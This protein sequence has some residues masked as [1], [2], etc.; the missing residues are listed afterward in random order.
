MKKYFFFFLLFLLSPL[1][2][3]AK[4]QYILQ[5]TENI[6]KLSGSC[7]FDVKLVLTEI[8]GEK[9]SI[10]SS[11]T[12]CKDGTFTFS[13]D[14]SIWNIADGQYVLWVNGEPAEKRI[15]MK[16]IVPITPLVT[17]KKK[18][19]PRNTFEQA[20]FNFGKNLTEMS[21]SLGIMEENLPE[22][23]YKK[24]TVKRTLIGFLRTTLDTLASFFGDFTSETDKVRPSEIEQ[25]PI[26][27][28]DDNT[29]IP[30]NTT[31]EVLSPDIVNNDNEGTDNTETENTLVPQEDD[32]TE[33]ENTLVPQEVNQE[34]TTVHSLPENVKTP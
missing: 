4:E 30:E 20:V 18:S 17:E 1:S 2:L 6:L 32:N 15:V 13:D 7:S 9:K 21:A 5:S 31:E 12:P 34:S 11:G 16:K 25:T 14:L 22:T 3:F 8:T 10:Y 29:I 26:V 23:D 28:P 24:D 27:S 19:V 33:A